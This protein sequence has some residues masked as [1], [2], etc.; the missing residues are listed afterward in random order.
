MSAPFFT[1]RANRAKRGFTLI[2]LLVVIAIIGLLATIAFISLS[3]ARA[4]A[5]DAKR[6]GDIVQLGKLLELYADD[7]QSGSPL[8]YPAAATLNCVVD[9]GNGQN[10]CVISDSTD[11]IPALKNGGYTTA[12]P[13]DPRGFPQWEPYRYMRSARYGYIMSFRLETQPQQDECHLQGIPP[14]YSTRCGRIP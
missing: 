8:E 11:W 3:R 7:H 5:R 6:L 2:E 14:P 13:Q 10:Q 9:D 4:K 12:L 1:A